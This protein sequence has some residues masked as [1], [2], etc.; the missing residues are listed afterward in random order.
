[1]SA[2][3]SDFNFVTQLSERLL[4]DLLKALYRL[5]AFPTAFEEELR[6]VQDEYGV[7]ITLG[8]F[9]TLG[10][11]DLYLDTGVP[12]GVGV[13][14]SILG[15]LNL[16][17]DLLPRGDELSTKYT[18]AFKLAAS[19]DVVATLGLQSRD[20]KVFFE[21]RFAQVRDLAFK[22]EPNPWPQDY[23]ELIQRLTKRI[24]I[25]Y[26]ST[27]IVTI[28][29]SAMLE[30]TT[31]AEWQVTA[32]VFKIM[33]GR[34]AKRTGN[35]TL[36][37]NTWPNRGLGQPASLVDWINPKYDFGIGINQTCVL[38]FVTRAMQRGEIP[39]VFN[40]NGQPDQNGKN[41]LQDVSFDFLQDKIVVSI[42]ATRTGLGAID[43]WIHASIRLQVIGGVLSVNISEVAIELPPLINAVG[44]VC[45]NI[46]WL[47][48]QQ[49]LTNFLGGLVQDAAQTTLDQFIRNKQIR[50]AFSGKI[51]GT[52]LIL[53]A[54]AE[55]VIITAD[56]IYCAGSVNFLLNRT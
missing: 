40:D 15:K 41:R 19:F 1:M 16:A 13:R 8:G 27:K 11:P 52:D 6:K 55:E 35:F 51:P 30:A 49:C 10:M 14:G 36:A 17:S 47:V 46:L 9:L 39:Q 50:L 31:F 5:R 33:L 4:N 22:L 25:V 18:T 54:A 53:E 48:I 28:P 56:E 7:G 45:F 37:F 3:T 32:P 43:V 26:L 2:I 38:Q 34:Q 23:Q 42:H 20:G 12:E 24:F 44:F 29:I 21:I